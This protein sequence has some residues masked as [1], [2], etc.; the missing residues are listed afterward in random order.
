[1]GDYLRFTVPLFGL[2][3]VGFL[4]AN[5]HVDRA[6]SRTRWIKFFTYVAIVH[7]VLAATVFG[8]RAVM[9]LMGAVALLGAVEVTRA[10]RVLRPVTRS[11][12]LIGFGVICAAALRFAWRADPFHVAHLYI[13]VA[14]FDGFSQTGGQLI[15][16]TKLAPRISP[17]KTIEGFVVGVAAA[18][19]AALA[20]RR[21]HGFDA[22]SA[23]L[24]G[25]SVSAAAVCGDL[26]ASW[27]K[28][29]AGIKDFGH[30][31]PGHGGVLDRFDSFLAAAAV[32]ALAA[33]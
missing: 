24:F 19:G 30:T 15:G 10:A 9:I 12:V 18:C 1:M 14:V 27:I 21:A 4:I 2:G 17:G 6:V 3:A 7:A 28:R 5:R 13:V 8:T 33:R 31:L 11:E 20:L 26:A 25:L 22:S 29:R 23:L 32:S 16:R